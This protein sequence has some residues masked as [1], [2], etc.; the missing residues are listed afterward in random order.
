MPMDSALKDKRRTYDQNCARKLL[1]EA[2]R[3]VIDYITSHDAT[4]TLTTEGH[5][6]KRSILNLTKRLRLEIH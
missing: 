6:Q 4:E 3:K 5:E 1:P 2:R